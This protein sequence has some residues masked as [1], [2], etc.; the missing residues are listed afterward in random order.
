MRIAS[1]KASP[2]LSGTVSSCIDVDCPSQ[3]NLWFVQCEIRPLTS[4]LP[5]FSWYEKSHNPVKRIVAVTFLYIFLHETKTPA[6]VVSAWKMV[7]APENMGGSVTCSR[8]PQIPYHAGNGNLPRL[9]PEF[10]LQYTYSFL[11]NDS[12]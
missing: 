4:L 8:S 3:Y 11:R 10:P 5:N 9:L 6:F 2:W 7:P 1:W 12:A